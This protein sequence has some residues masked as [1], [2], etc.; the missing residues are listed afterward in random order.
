MVKL[1]SVGSGEFLSL[2]KL[3]NYVFCEIAHFS[4]L[5]RGGEL[6]FEKDKAGNFNL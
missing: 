5:I 3:Q 6:L 4:S 2:L 1:G